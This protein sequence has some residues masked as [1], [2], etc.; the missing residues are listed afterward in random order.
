MH[1]PV[2]TAVATTQKD[3]DMSQLFNSA[4]VPL[5]EEKVKAAIGTAALLPT[6]QDEVERIRAAVV[7]DRYSDIQ[8]KFSNLTMNMDGMLVSDMGTFQYTKH[9]LKQAATKIKPEDVKDLGGYLAVCPPELRCINYS[10]WHTEAYGDADEKTRGNIVQLRAM[11]NEYGKVLRAVVGRDYKPLDDLPI[12]EAMGTILQPGSKMRGARGDL[13]SRFDILWP[14]MEREIFPGDPLL[15]ALRLS[16]SETGSGS[17]RLNPMVYHVKNHG[18]IMICSRMEDVSIRHVGEAARKLEVRYKKVMEDINPFLEQYRKSYSDEIIQEFEDLDQ[19]W[20]ALA[21][22]F[23]FTE[24]QMALVKKS[25]DTQPNTR[26]GVVSAIILAAQDFVISQG[27]EMQ[28]AAGY[29]VKYGWN[30]VKRFIKEDEE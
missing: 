1:Y 28:Q 7:A 10:Y 21:K 5:R 26:A 4:L 23:K 9:A 24:L 16:N 18:C 19:M 20:D 15:V 30:P 3:R 22:C 2:V 29:L 14:N 25:F 6:Y 17:V 13:R 27:E 12:L 11:E 8:A